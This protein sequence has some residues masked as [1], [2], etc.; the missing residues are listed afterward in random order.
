MLKKV[1]THPTLLLVVAYLGG[2]GVCGFLVFR[3]DCRFS[4][5][6]A[7]TSYVAYFLL[8]NLLF[9]NVVG[10]FAGFARA[11]KRMARPKVA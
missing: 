11:A 5:A 4:D 2:I 9:A 6:D 7:D 10:F 3:F 1:I 8:W